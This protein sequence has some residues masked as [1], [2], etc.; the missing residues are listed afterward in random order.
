M[1]KLMNLLQKIQT[2]EPDMAVDGSIALLLQ[3]IDLERD[4]DN[5]DLD[6]IC[7]HNPLD[8]TDYIVEI[9]GD[10]SA[11]MQLRYL[12]DGINVQVQV[13]EERETIGIKHLGIIY[14]VHTIPYILRWKHK[15]ALAG[16]QKHIDD[17]NKIRR[18]LSLEE[19][20]HVVF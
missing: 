15:Y 13:T 5:V 20:K 14:H 7:P 1:N 4:W 6:F 9:K 2:I 17:L 11:D 12:I 3:G 8:F 18:L 16:H 19:I 10:D